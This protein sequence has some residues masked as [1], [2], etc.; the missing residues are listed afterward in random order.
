MRRVPALVTVFGLAVAGCGF[1]SVDPD[2][3][4]SISGRALDSSGKPLG[5]AHVVLVRQADV[6]QV[7]FGSILAVGTLSTICFS[8]APLAICEK[9]HTT[10]TDSDGRYHFDVKGS[11][12]QGSLGTEATMNVVFSGRSSRT[13]T[14]VSFAARENDVTVPDARLWDL[15]AAVSRGGSLRLSWRPLSRSAGSKATYSVQLYDTRTGAALWTQPASGGRAEI[16]PRLLEDRHGAVAVSA[17]A[18]LPGGSGTA[19]VRASYLSPQLPV[20]ASAGAPPSRGRP[21]AAVTGTAPAPVRVRT[22]CGAT[23]GDLGAPAGLTAPGKEPVTGVVIDLGR[24]R[25]VSL[26]VARGFSGQFLVETSTDGKT[27]VT[28]A[29]G[30][31]PA[32]SVK[33]SGRPGARYVRLHSPVGLDESLSAEVSVW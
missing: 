3:S 16:D 18:E 32:Y 33:P 5:N 13:S 17:G 12:T 2:S 7:I 1:S 26:V 22:P 23:D 14:T 11:D 8:P 10:T 19:T 24:A 27:F 9:V 31:G 30:S 15:A 4:V 28:V 29:T 21:C 20:T 6:G 25:P